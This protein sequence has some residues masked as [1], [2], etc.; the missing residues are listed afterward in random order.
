VAVIEPSAVAPEFGANKSAAFLAGK[1]LLF[2]FSCKKRTVNEQLL[3]QLFFTYK[4]KNEYS[5]YYLY[6]LCPLK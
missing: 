4:D 3:S 2:P 1:Y 5:L 6:F